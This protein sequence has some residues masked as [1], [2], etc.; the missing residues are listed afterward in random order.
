MRD[1]RAASHVLGACSAMAGMDRLR[2]RPLL[3]AR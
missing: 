2:R 1:Q 3:L